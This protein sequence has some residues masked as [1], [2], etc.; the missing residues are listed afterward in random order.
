MFILQAPY[1]ALAS[2]MI[3]PSPDIGNNLGLI[4][5]VVVVKMEDGGRR[6]FVKPGGGL[7]RHRWDFLLSSDKTEEFVDFIE[8][9]RGADFRVEWRNRVIIGK[10]AINPIELSGQGRAGG[11][12]GGEAYETTLEMIEQ[13]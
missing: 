5:Q 7:R 12:P 11:W 3:L 1:P 13:L 4:S 10:L 2:T 6:S 8:R 9:Y